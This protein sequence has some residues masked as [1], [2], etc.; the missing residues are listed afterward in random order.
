MS[1]E[2]GKPKKKR[3][4]DE[5]RK[6]MRGRA[7]NKSCASVNLLLGTQSGTLILQENRM[8]PLNSVQMFPT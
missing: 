7:G 6:K 1:K 8:S 4:R 2:L 5:F 3:E